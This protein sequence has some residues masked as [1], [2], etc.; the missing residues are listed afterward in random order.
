MK[1]RAILIAS[2]AVLTPLTLYVL[3][4]GGSEVAPRLQNAQTDTPPPQTT[5]TPALQNSIAPGVHLT[6]KDRESLGKLL[7]VFKASIDFYGKVQDQYGYPVPGAKVH[8]SA[9]DQYFGDSSKYEGTSDASGG[10]SI[11]GI[12]GAGLFVDVFKD[13][14]D[15]IDKRSGGSFGYGMP[16]ERRPPT[17][18]NPAIFILRKKTEAEP[19]IA[20][21]RDVVIPKDGTPVEVNLKTGKAVPKGQGDLKI[22]CWADDQHT[23]ARRRYEWHF[24]LSIP[25]GGLIERQNADFDFEA[26]TDGYQSIEEFKM[27]QS[28][29]RWRDSFEKQY[30]TKLGDGTYA[31]M[32]FR[33]TTGGDHFA[34]ITSYLN[35]KPGS[36]NLEFDSKK[37]IKP[38]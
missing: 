3:F 18:D 21:D 13:G 7:T 32:R 31:R 33:I 19:L 37:V 14:Y 26:P 11:T 4:R 10:F 6:T 23:D 9:A 28:T 1:A 5:T 22:E 35:P 20:V 38:L 16:S 24:R 30:F 12:K 15:G 17:R 2:L 27:P 25:A 8:Y 36:R 34:S 29:E